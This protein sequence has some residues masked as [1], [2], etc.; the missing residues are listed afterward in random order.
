MNINKLPPGFDYMYEGTKCH[1]CGK[2]PYDEKPKKERATIRIWI[3]EEIGPKNT[4]YYR[5]SMWHIV[6]DMKADYCGVEDVDFE[7]AVEKMIALLS[8][9]GVKI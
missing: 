9:R 1:F 3:D 4:S 6:Y 8:E 7:K 5:P 2:N